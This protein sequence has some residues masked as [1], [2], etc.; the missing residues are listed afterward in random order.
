MT[1]KSK[2]VAKK[3]EPKKVPDIYPIYL[4]DYVAENL[5]LRHARKEFED[6]TRFDGN[7]AEY[8]FN[9]YIEE[10][11]DVKIW[12]RYH[13]D[14]GFIKSCGSYCQKTIRPYTQKQL[15]EYK[16]RQMF[17]IAEVEYFKRLR[18]KELKDIEKIQKEI[19]G[20]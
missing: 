19:F 11:G 6:S 5:V 14:N 17:E 12:V 10:N 4:P 13:T 15:V 1:A 7:N 16:K 3:Q 20:E 9:A 2:I 18:E 8:D